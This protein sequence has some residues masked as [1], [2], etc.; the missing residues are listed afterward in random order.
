MH[1]RHFMLL[2]A[3]ISAVM[4]SVALAACGGSSSKVLSASTPTVQSGA[5]A[6]VPTVVVAAPTVAAQPTATPTPPTLV[7]PPPTPTPEPPTPV[8]PPPEPVLPAP[9][10]PAALPAPAPQAPS[11]PIATSA[12]RVITVALL[13][14]APT[15]IDASAGQ[16]LTINMVNTDFM[17]PH[18]IGLGSNRTT[19]CPGPCSPSFTFTVPRGAT[20]L[21]CTLHADMT[22]TVNGR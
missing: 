4:L 10:P 21:T 11:A 9:R 18:D 20:I 16:T 12:T 13:R 22:V 8:P 1:K 14:F 19:T 6:A 7:P 2:P 15:V 17:V 3:V 5:E